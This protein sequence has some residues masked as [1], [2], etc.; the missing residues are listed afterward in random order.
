MKKVTILAAMATAAISLTS[1]DWQSAV[2]SIA[3]SAM[4]KEKPDYDYNKGVVGSEAGDYDAVY[5]KI[6]E[7]HN[8]SNDTLDLYKVKSEFSKPAYCTVIAEGL[9]DKSKNLITGYNASYSKDNLHYL[10][11]GQMVIKTS[12]GKRAKYD[13]YKEILF[14]YADVKPLIDKVPDLIKGVKEKENGAE[15]YVRSWEIQKNPKTLA[16]EIKIN[17]IGNEPTKVIGKTY[18]FDAQGN[19]I[20]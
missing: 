11:S 14:S 10:T 15:T 20:K 4:G 1:C 9:T 17:T 12:E 19:P 13:D 5:Q 3:D 18:H 7:K 6:L 8:I 16:F 2:H